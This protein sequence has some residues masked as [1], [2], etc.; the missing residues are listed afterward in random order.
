MEPFHDLLPY[1]CAEQ[2]TRWANGDHV[3]IEEF[4]SQYEELKEDTTSLLD[5]IYHEIYLRE[6]HDLPIDLE[7]FVTRFPRL[8]AD[9]ALMFEVH[10]LVD[11]GNLEV[12]DELSTKDP[13]NEFPDPVADVLRVLRDTY[14]FSELPRDVQE[15]IAGQSIYRVFDHGDFLVRQGDA[16]DSLL[17]IKTG[18]VEIRLNHPE[19]DSEVVGYC[20]INNV[21]GEIGIFTN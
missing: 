20:G 13:E 7:M 15:N 17:I 4:I 18:E 12:S 6:I 10:Q 14:P 8:S 21:I 2:S 11:T 16:S 5:L 1:L 9:I 19:Q 3:P